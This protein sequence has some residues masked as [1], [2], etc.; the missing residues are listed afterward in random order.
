[1]SYDKHSKAWSTLLSEV[2]Q[3]MGRHLGIAKP[4]NEPICLSCHATGGKVAGVRAPEP[5]YS[6]GVGCESCHGAGEGYLRSHT[7]QGASHADNISKGMKDLFPVQKRAEL[8]LS[9]HQIGENTELTHR[10]FGAG[11]PRVA[12]ELDTFSRSQPNHWIVD[13]DYVKRK[14][15]YISE[16]AWFIGNIVQAEKV[17]D[18][19][20]KGGLEL[21]RYSCA[22]C[23]HSLTLQQW[24]T[25]DYG[26]RPGELKPNLAA[27]LMAQLGASV[28][29]PA[30]KP[31]LIVV[32]ENAHNGKVSAGAVE[33]LK[34][35]QTVAAAA[36]YGESEQKALFDTLVKYGK[37]R[38]DHSY[39]VAEQITMGLESILSSTIPKERNNKP[40]TSELFQLLKDP[41]NFY[42]DRF[43]EA[44]RR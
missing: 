31:K 14:G 8:C 27:L 42:P 41:N 16:Q 22:S 23:H 36:H 24:Q 38:N 34:S 1:M 13:E 33:L 26:G 17:L 18:E 39:E 11:H 37:S 7:V 15:T 12:F 19:L 43:A 21:S 2:S 20:A 5:S 3:K 30:F 28:Y 35:I 44:L 10:I 32:I 4:E 6:D 25:R 29:A 9:C 40:S